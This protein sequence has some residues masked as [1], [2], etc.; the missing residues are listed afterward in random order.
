MSIGEISIANLYTTLNAVFNAAFKETPIWFDRIAMTVPS[1][2][3]TLDYKM[4]L[5]WPGVREWVGDRT[6]KSLIATNMTVTAK[7]W[8]S[9]IEVDQF[10]VD[11]DQAGLYLPKVQMMGLR[12]KQ[13][14]NT[15][16]AAFIV[17][18][19]STTTYS[20]AYDGKAFFATDHII[21][22]G[23][24]GTSTS[25]SNY[26]SGAST[27]WYLF[28]TRMPVK[29]FIFQI[30]QNF[31]LTAMDQAQTDN[32]F[33]R[34]KYQY[35]VH[36]RYNMAYALPQLAYKSTQTLNSTNYAAARAAM[37]SFTNAD[38]DPLGVMPN[39][40]VVPPTLEASAKELLQ[41]DF[42]IG[43]LATGGTADY[44]GGGK[45]NIWKGTCELLVLPELA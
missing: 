9:T 12:A 33:R 17:A 3:G 10:D 14:P 26:S 1:S 45:T 16:L 39:L 21:S 15:L 31:Q 35:G 20:A 4:I 7:A 42:V 38:G 36:A 23:V 32:V 34:H 41:G 24:S 29:P 5:D 6:A 27:S 37:M 8:E 22:D 13:A 18:G 30:R 44:V 40:M 28:D 19:T 11:D 25:F 43:S 2:A